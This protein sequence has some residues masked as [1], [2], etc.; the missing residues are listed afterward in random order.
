MPGSANVKVVF[1]R[2]SMLVPVALL[3]LLASSCA[4]EAERPALAGGTAPTAAQAPTTTEVP[5][6]TTIPLPPGGRQPTA[7]EKL[8]VILAGD[9]VMNGLAPAVA[10]GLNEGREADAKFELAPSIARDAASRVLWQTQLEEFHPDLV[11]ML[12]GTWE[13]RDPN[14]DPGDPAWA[15]RY[16]SEV[17]DP[18]AAMVTDSGAKLLWI[19]MPAVPADS[20]TLQ[21]VALNTQFEALAARDDNVDYI[22]G[23]QYLNG[24]DGQWTDVLP[25]ADGS[26]ERVRR[27]DGLHLCPAG[28]ER[29]AIPILQ[30]IQQQWNVAI[31]FNWQNGQ[32]RQPPTL[33]HPEECPAV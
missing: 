23:G 21:F 30:V 33:D 16:Q 5:T 3:S 1:R 25:A 9:S 14:F 10:T 26:P 6:T 24:P 22:E 11:V 8:R 15:A 2:S 12:I 20:D 29:L 28:A 27:S 17:L 7:D 13:K 18:F 31:G 32:W 19:G 4:T